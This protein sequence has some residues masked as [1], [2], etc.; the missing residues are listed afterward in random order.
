MSGA[1]FCGLSNLYYKSVSQLY[2]NEPAAWFPSVQV[3]SETDI[4]TPLKP[5]KNPSK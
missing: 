5:R 3:E 4:V 2:A 1:K